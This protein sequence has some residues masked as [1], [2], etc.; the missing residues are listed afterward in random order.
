MRDLFSKLKGFFQIF[1]IEGTDFKNGNSAFQIPAK[2]NSNT[3]FYL[4]T[5]M[6]FFSRETLSELNSV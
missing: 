5:E 3:K 6:F 2:N 1:R 4:K